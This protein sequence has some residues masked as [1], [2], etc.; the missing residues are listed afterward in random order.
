MAPNQAALPQSRDADADAAASS[1]LRLSFLAGDVP[2]RVAV[3][4]GGC[5]GL[6]A[7]WHLHAN[8]G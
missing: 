2:R 8:T 5:A 4:G 1:L 6:A 3:V 7:A